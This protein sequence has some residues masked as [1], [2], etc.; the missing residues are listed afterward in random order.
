M[1][2]VHGRTRSRRG[3]ERPARRA[4]ARPARARAARRRPAAPRPPAARRR[5]A[6]APSGRC[7]RSATRATPARRGGQRPGA[8]RGHRALAADR[9]ARAADGRAELHHRLVERRRAAG[10]EQLRGP[11]RELARRVERRRRGARARGARWC[12]RRRPAR[13]H[14]N[15]PTAAAVYGPTPG[16][17]VRSSG[18]PC[19]ATSPR[20]AL[21]RQRAA[22]VAEPA[23]VREHLARGR[24]RERAR[25][26]EALQPALVV[27]DDP[28]RLGLLEHHLGHEQRVRV[29]RRAPRQR[30]PDALVPVQQRRRRSRQPGGS[31]PWPRSA[32]AS[33]SRSVNESTWIQASSGPPGR[34]KRPAQLERRSGPSGRGSRPRTSSSA[35]QSTSHGA[36]RPRGQARASPPAA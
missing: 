27:R 3:R 20:G 6:R 29:A 9:R 15:E 8:A 4:R 14:A 21:Q 7:P 31:R 18:Q 32:M 33:A 11:P 24:G 36:E 12:R 35:C 25:V 17:S 5:S 19:A 26:G 2:Q 23:P 30:P 34:S 13:S 10:R 16:S 22:V 28:R 1:S